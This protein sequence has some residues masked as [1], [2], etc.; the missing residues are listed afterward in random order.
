MTIDHNKI[1]Y[2]TIQKAVEAGAQLFSEDSATKDFDRACDHILLLIED[3]FSCYTRNS[4]GSS[5]LMAITA[6]E[7]IAKAEIGIYRRKKQT[8]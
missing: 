1:G 8:M 4:F 2:K 5:V 6:I 3:S 7:E